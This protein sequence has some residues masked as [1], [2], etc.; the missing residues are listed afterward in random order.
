MP[1][2]V[3]DVYDKDALSSDFIAR[4]LIPLKDAIYSKDF[5]KSYSEKTKMAQMQDDTNLSSLGRD[6]DKFFNIGI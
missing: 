5:E 2:F 1:P 6:P 3:C 4:T